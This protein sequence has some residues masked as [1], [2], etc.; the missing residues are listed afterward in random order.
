MTSISDNNPLQGIEN[1]SQLEKF[2]SEFEYSPSEKE[3]HGHVFKKSGSTDG[4]SVSLE[5]LIT[6]IKALQSGTVNLE[7]SKEFLMNLFMKKISPEA[8][9]ITLL[10]GRFEKIITQAFPELSLTQDEEKS[11]VED[12]R[13]INMRTLCEC[14]SENPISIT[15]L[16]VL[17]EI[18]DGWNISKPP[19]KLSLIQPLIDVLKKM[20]RFDLLFLTHTKDESEKIRS[21]AFK[22]LYYGLFSFLADK[23]EKKD[24]ESDEALKYLYDLYRTGGSQALPNVL[25]KSIEKQYGKEFAEL[26]ADEAM[27]IIETLD[28]NDVKALQTLLSNF[29]MT[30]SEGQK[31]ILVERNANIQFTPEQLTNLHKIINNGEYEKVEKI[32]S[33][34]RNI[35]RLIG[36][37]EFENCE[38][39]EDYQR[40]NTIEEEVAAWVLA[41]ERIR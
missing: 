25:K 15:A 4:I 29:R 21:E 6:K 36:H 19:P 30:L 20:P 7:K 34:F 9:G 28:S 41:L 35:E 39:Y 24:A 33:I 26:Y 1:W 5:Q 32:C 11:R 18:L 14:I 10:R 17:K 40:Y 23:V 37:D 27:D 22:S 31:K 8:P 2:S 38:E 13:M 12:K 16:G 3:L